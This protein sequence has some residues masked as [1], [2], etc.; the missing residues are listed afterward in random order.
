MKVSNLVNLLRTKKQNKTHTQSSRIFNY[1]FFPSFLADFMQSFRIKIKLKSHVT[2]A[3]FQ[4][5][6]SE[7]TIQ[8]Y[9]YKI[10]TAHCIQV[11][12]YMY[13]LISYFFKRVVYWKT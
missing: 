12:E 13:L 5:F 7:N 10:K 2:S 4:L 9:T 6:S 3:K 11:E 8:R 1:L